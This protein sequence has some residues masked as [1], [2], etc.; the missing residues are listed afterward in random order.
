MAA[1]VLFDSHCDLCSTSVQFIVN[2]DPREKFRFASIHSATGKQLLRRCGM[3]PEDIDSLVVV[4]G[5]RCF[6]KGDAALEIAGKLGGLWPMTSI[7]RVLPRR[8]RDRSYDLIARNR[9]RILRKEQ[10]CML[11]GPELRRRILD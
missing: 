5:N 2:R 8:I 1:I 6:R 11:P 3:N 4:E 10:S 7:L 9:N